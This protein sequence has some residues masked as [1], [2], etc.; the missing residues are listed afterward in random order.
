M[1]RL[2]AVAVAA[3]CR[4]T[5]YWCSGGVHPCSVVEEETLLLGTLHSNGKA[6]AV[7]FGIV[8]CEARSNAFRCAVLVHIFA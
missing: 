6:D 3:A 7:L 2:I 1:R 4:H 5:H 8:V